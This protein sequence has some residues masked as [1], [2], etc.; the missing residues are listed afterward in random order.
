VGSTVQPTL[1]TGLVLDIGQAILAAGGLEPTVAILLDAV[2]RLIGA[3]TASI[4]Q[5]ESASGLLRCTH[6]AG[7]D[8]RAVKALPPLEPGEGVTGLAVA[9]ARPVWTGDVLRD[10]AIRLPPEA[11]AELDRLAH[12]SVLAA[13]LLVHGTARG[14]LVGH[15]RARGTFD[16]SDAELLRALA[17]L[18]GVAL[19]NARLREETA[20][21]ARRA[22]VV[23]E[24]ARI[25]GSTLD[26][27]ALLAALVREIQRVVPCRRASF[28][29]YEPATHAITF[30]ELFAA[31]ER[32]QPE[33]PVWT[34]PAE[35]TQ[36][37][38]V[39]QTR[40]TVVDDDLRTSSIPLHAQRVAEGSL[41]SVSVPIL[42]GDAC[43][44]VLN[45]ASDRPRA[46]AAEH[47]AFLEALGPHLA[48]AIDKARLFEQVAARATRASRLAALSRLVTES[49]DVEH[50]Q[51]FVIQ[52][53]ADLLGADLTSLYLLD[54]TGQWLDLVATT[55]PT[56]SA[57]MARPGGARRRLDVHASMIGHVATTRRPHY[58]ADVQ[59]DPLM[60]NKDWARSRGYRSQLTVPLIVGQAA[61]GV[62][63]V[64]F[65]E[66]RALSPDEVELLE[67]LAA[68]AASA[69]QNARLYDRA[70]ESARLK[71]EFVANMSHE[72][73]TPMNGV[74]GMTGLLLETRLDTEQRDY[75]ATIRSS[76]DA[77]LTI[78]NDILDFSKIEAGKLVLE[79]VD[80]DV[81]Q[82]VEGVADLL[83]E[84]A[85]RKGLELITVIEPEVPALLRGDPGRLRQVLTN[86]AGNAVKFTERGDVVIQVGLDDSREIGAGSAADSGSVAV[87]STPAVPLRFEVRDTGPGIAPEL[88]SRLFQAF[89]QA[90]GSTTRRHGGTGLGLTIARQLVELMGGQIGLESEPGRGSTFWFTV[91]LEQV[92]DRSV[93]APPTEAAG[94]RVLVV[95]DN[96]TSR[97][98][99]ER[100]LTAW[101][102]RATSTPDAVTALR[103]L[104]AAVS[105]GQPYD[106]AIVDL[107]MPDVDGLA[108]ARQ[109]KADPALSD[110]PLVL[111]TSIAAHDRDLMGAQHGIAVTLTKPVRS[112][113]LLDAIELALRLRADDVPV[114]SRPA[115][116]AVWTASGDP[117]HTGVRV[118]VAEDNPVNQRVAVRML[119]RLGHGADVAADGREVL[120]RLGTRAYALI[121][122]D[123]QMP[124]LDGFEVTRRIRA[125]ERP[126]GRMPIIAMTAAAMP[127]DR[128]RCL[129]AGMDDYISKPVRM[130]ALRSVLERWLPRATR[131]DE[132]HDPAGGEADGPA[133][134]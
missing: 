131:S 132:R 91:P 1:S 97:M 39:I 110:L 89:V 48:V 106:L 33:R 17:S 66:L 25:I 6:A 105:H 58:S 64:L 127:E 16:E 74:I 60:V 9:E 7:P 31:T 123:C 94:P 29:F 84:P 37:W 35:Q 43:V 128:D 85:H 119:E 27:P 98:F 99:L 4:F 22:Q 126:D 46:F 57:E 12:R 32:G 38:P 96:G 65:R 122:M 13:P 63:T 61:I 15:S 49:L 134:T 20:A 86:L 40:Q 108:L 70:L 88:R 90:D 69:I 55:D 87:R 114:A 44:G 62:L 53:G 24:L 121:L 133:P 5:L 115:P 3:E 129:A 42:Q 83:A 75:V 54:E 109:I 23:A 125:G 103:L 45:L 34:V 30:H 92:A 107:R 11:E 120:R 76:A 28:A 51:H 41:S 78:I 82:L 77:L 50:V 95:D 56:L 73:R 117:T 21:Q 19:E 10:L 36:S 100:Q 101:R 112:S 81:R 80:C 72:I 104:R 47:V 116:K 79:V 26:L 8:A 2:Q 102:M 18:A 93:P 118:L 113:Q 67:S 59:A 52:A 14:A 130:N 71:S 68:Q 111:L 124:E